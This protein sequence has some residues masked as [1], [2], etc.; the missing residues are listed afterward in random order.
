[1]LYI[2][3]V[4][5]KMTRWFD[6]GIGTILYQPDIRQYTCAEM[7]YMRNLRQEIRK[8]RAK[9]STCYQRQDLAN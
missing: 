9:L 8:M 4:I 3:D 2:T 1:M 5:G 7:L 6:R